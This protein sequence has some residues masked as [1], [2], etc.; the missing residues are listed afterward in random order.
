MLISMII[1]PLL[2]SLVIAGI[3][4][5]SKGYDLQIR[6]ISLSISLIV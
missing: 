2:G 4:K 5:D 6:Q 3:S 1:L